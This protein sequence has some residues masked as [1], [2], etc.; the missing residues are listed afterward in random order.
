M[1]QKSFC[2]LMSNIFANGPM[3]VGSAKYTKHTWKLCCVLI[4]EWWHKSSKHMVKTK[5]AVMCYQCRIHYSLCLFELD[6]LHQSYFCF[7]LE[8]EKTIEG[9]HSCLPHTAQPFPLWTSK[10]YGGC[11]QFST[12]MFFINST[13]NKYPSHTIWCLNDTLDSWA[14]CCEVDVDITSF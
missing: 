7:F 10:L 11:I 3:I 14:E 12:I 9:K 13:F 2:I 6:A 4:Q 5:V 8:K 1:A